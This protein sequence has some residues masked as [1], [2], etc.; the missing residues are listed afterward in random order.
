MHTQ[1]YSIM[2]TLERTGR[3]IMLLCLDDSY[4]DIP[5]QALNKSIHVTRHVDVFKILQSIALL[6]I[7]DVMSFANHW[8][9][10]AGQ[11]Q[12]FSTVRINSCRRMLLC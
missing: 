10:A 3:L 5:T 7:M 12:E 8:L 2:R 1:Q 4:S 11:K 9:A 6:S